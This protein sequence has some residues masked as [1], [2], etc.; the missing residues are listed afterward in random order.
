LVNEFINFVLR[1]KNKKKIFSHTRMKKKLFLILLVSA[2][3]FSQPQNEKNSYP[4]IY[5]AFLWHMH[6]PIYWPYESIVTT[7]AQGR[8]PYSVFDIHNERT[9]PYT[10]WPKDAV[11][12]GISAGLDH[13]G[14][15]VSFTG[16]L[17][18]NLNNLESNSNGNFSNWKSSWNYIKN[19]KTSLGNPRIDMVG[20]GYFHPLMGLI[21]YNDIRRQIQM[22]KQTF[23]QNFPGTYS[24]GIF[25][26]ENAFSNRMIPALVDEGIE[27]ALVDNIHFERAVKDYPFNTGGN[28][29]E[30]NK[31]DV[32][33]E[34]PND[35]IQ[36]NGVWAP[37][38]VS[39]KWARLPHYVE[40]INPE[41]GEKKKM[42]AIPADRYLGNE[43]GRGGFGALNY[44]NV[45]S[46]FES[47]NTDAQHP[48]LLVLHHDGDNYGGGSSA[49]YGSNF[50]NFVDWLKNNPQRFVCT[51]IQDY[52]QLFP[53]AQDD[54]IYVEDGSWSGADNGDPEFKK[55]LGDPG[56]DGYSPDRNSWGVITAAKN[57]VETANQINPN[58]AATVQAWKYLLVGEA[59]D[60]WY[61]DGSID[62]IWDAHPTRAAN[63]AV[64]AIQAI[65]TSGTDLTP[66][67]IFSPQREPYN[68]GGTEWTISQPSDFTVWSYV[69]D[70][71]GLKSVTLKYRT[72]NDGVNPASSIQNETY[73]GG[74]EV[75]A[76][77]S[78]TMSGKYITPKTSPLPLVK[79]QEFS[80]QIK[81]LKNF[82]VDYY[83][84]AV[85]SNNN[86]AKSPI[87]H[88]WVGDGNGTNPVNT[89]ISWTPQSPTKDSVLTITVSG[90]SQ[91]AKLHW[92]VNGFTTPNN[93][94]WPDG[95]VLYSDNKAVESP[96]NFINNSD[97]LQLKIGPFN[98]AAQS[99]TEINFVIHYNDNTW[100]NNN[101]KDYKI[102]LSDSSTKPSTFVMD[103]NL[104]SG[105]VLAA[106]ANGAHLYRAWNGSELYIATESAQAQGK[107]V[108]IFVSSD[109]STLMAAPWAKQG[110][111][112]SWAAYL[113]NESTNNYCGWSDQS[114]TVKTSA[115]AFLEG[116]INLQQELGTLPDK[117]YLA[118]GQYQTQDNGVLVSQIPSAQNGDGNIDGNEFSLFQF[119]VTEAG[120]SKYIPQTFVLHQNYPNPFN[121]V[122]TI[123]FGIPHTENKTS[124]TLKIF[125]ILGNELTTL[126]NG[127]IS[128]GMH[129]IKFNGDN[130]SSGVYFYQ[131]QADNIVL[132][133]KMMLL[134]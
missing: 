14:A 10:S 22:H 9:G 123:R 85:D 115:G 13:L 31:A 91:G 68:P 77:E 12:K 24:K 108:F 124:I 96:F 83:I 105:A 28:I 84:E 42:I 78:L 21:D 94:Y 73:A 44:D 51:T 34:N 26:P 132:H 58:D 39:A 48:I 99:V 102:S 134:K 33:D 29:Y 37:T 117:I 106:T 56:P 88:V 17:I 131:L 116:T 57:Y 67:T 49:Y 3:C 59:S 71:S 7:Q 110:K 93:V 114:G 79:A 23:A 130:F 133:K 126:L 86:V 127:E 11:Q 55:W 109:P 125:D 89:G 65:A 32:Q 41:T 120:Q 1:S 101:N 98:N 6:Q 16:S 43:D 111:V 100:D 72:D 38:K 103:G 20:F 129:E 113:A 75:S 104:D 128:P 18:E 36:L 64:Q 4:P 82:L 76:W 97:T 119:S 80:A 60:Y 19:Q 70:V 74:D 35:W 69:Y 81:G 30:P 122:T 52:L 118:V 92:G 112:G 15:Q 87:K 121:P 95:T 61:W 8:Y 107:D 66:P 53:P 5:I 27:W 40:N 47:S 62:G 63:L 2:V 54:I 90:A 46:Q 25:P 50:Q 45:M